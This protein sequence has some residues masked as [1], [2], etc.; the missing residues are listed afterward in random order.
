MNGDIIDCHTIGP[1]SLF[2][3]CLLLSKL[4]VQWLLVHRT[5][6][7]M[8]MSIYTSQKLFLYTS[9]PWHTLFFGIRT[10]IEGGGLLDDYFA[11]DSTGTYIGF[12]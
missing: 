9:Y 8:P 3:K 10:L 5:F 7:T 6:Y 1:F 4:L 12:S 11:T 2:E